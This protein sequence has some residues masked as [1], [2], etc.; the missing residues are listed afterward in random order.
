[1]GTDRRA[2]H[3]QL[4]AR[5]ASCGDRELADLTPA[6]QAIGVGGG[7]WVTE[8]DGVPVFVK[9]I[10]LSDREV[11]R[12]RSTANLFG[13]PVF[14]QYGVGGPG[15]NAWRELAANQAVTEAVLAG[16]TAAFPLLHHWRVLPGRPAIADE[17]ADLDAAVAAMAGDAAVRA[18]LE[19]LADASHSLVLFCEYLPVAMDDWLADDPAGKAELVERQ[20]MEIVESL[21]RLELLHMDGHFGNMRVDGEQLHLT[22]FGLATSPRFELSVDEWDFVRRNARHDA[23]Y[24]AMVLVNWLVRDVCRVGGGVADRYEFVRR[25]ADGAVPDGVPPGV[26]AVLT[27]H[28]PVAARMNDFYWKVFGGDVLAEYADPFVEVS[29]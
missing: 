22:D 9:Q 13:L 28:A 24:A 26:A 25:C 27:R 14:A 5:L 29:S 11:E 21:G 18:R 20:L 1:M 16:E 12:P 23:G 2:R 8:F 4:S 15:F 7:S 17:H 3:D 19:A 10:P 6:D